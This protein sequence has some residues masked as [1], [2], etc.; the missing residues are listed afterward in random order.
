MTTR[1][2]LFI[3][4]SIDAFFL[5]LV[6]VFF[7]EL[8]LLR[9][10]LSIIILP[11]I[12]FVQSHL[13]D[14]FQLSQCNLFLN[15]IANNLPEE[16]WVVEAKTQLNWVY[17]V[18]I[19]STRESDLVRMFLT[20]EFGLLVMLPCLIL[21]NEFEFIILEFG[22]SY[23]VIFIIPLDYQV[24]FFFFFLQNFHWQNMHVVNIIVIFLR[25]FCHISVDVSLHLK[26][27]NQGQWSCSCFD[28]I[29]L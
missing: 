26:E 18:L 15:G 22:L 21:V 8:D 3:W 12:E 27:K 25:L 1:S 6:N 2:V 19:L 20:N 16:N 4:V 9:N 17:L 11:M 23:S 7:D 10:L 24:K 5:P 13:N 28:T 14:S 29:I